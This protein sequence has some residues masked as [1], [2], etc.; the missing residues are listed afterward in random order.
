MYSENHSYMKAAPKVMPPILWCWPP[1][2][3]VD[4]S[5]TAVEVEPSCQNSVARII[6]LPQT[7]AV[8]QMA[9]DMEVRVKERR[10]NEFLHAE[11]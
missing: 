1:T 5:A 9:P 4:I 3:Q 6:L 11:K 7:A 2:S 10:D 8:R